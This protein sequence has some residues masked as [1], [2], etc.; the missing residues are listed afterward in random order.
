MIKILNARMRYDE[1]VISMCW[2]EDQE[3]NDWSVLTQ[4]SNVK[5]VYQIGKSRC[6]LRASRPLSDVGSVFNPV[7]ILNSPPIYFLTSCIFL[8]LSLDSRKSAV[9]AYLWRYCTL[10]LAVRPEI[11]L[12]FT[13]RSC[14]LHFHIILKIF[15]QEVYVI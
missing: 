10:G 14:L 1:S 4:Q 12:D 7:N 13:G 3:Q 8:V 9:K 11:R 6:L 15:Y 2:G 5:C